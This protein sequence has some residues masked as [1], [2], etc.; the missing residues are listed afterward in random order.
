MLNFIQSIFRPEDSR[1]V[2]TVLG[3]DF[4][5]AHNALLTKHTQKVEYSLVR[6]PNPNLPIPVSLWIRQTADVQSMVFRLLENPGRVISML[7]IEPHDARPIVFENGTITGHSM[8]QH[9]HYGVHH[10]DFAFVSAKGLHNEDSI[11]IPQRKELFG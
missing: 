4:S 8:E 2:I 3:S 6:K 10:L 1:D 5:P 11:L 7:K 9:R